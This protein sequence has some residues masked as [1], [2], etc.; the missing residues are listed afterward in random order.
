MNDHASATSVMK[1]TGK[2]AIIDLYIDLGTGNNGLIL[3]N[4]G[5]KL[6]GVHINGSDLASAKTCLHLDHASTGDHAIIENIDIEGH[7]TYATGLLIDNFTHSNFDN[8]H[9]HECLEGIKIVGATSDEN[10]F[11]NI[12][13]GDC[14]HASGIG[15]NID[16]GNE[17]H[18]NKISFHN[19]TKN[20]DDEVKDHEWTNKH[21]HFPIEIIPNDLDGFLT[22]AG[23]ATSGIEADWGDPV[24]FAAEDEI[25]FPFRV[26]GVHVEPTA[27]EWHELRFSGNAGVTYYDRILFEGNKREAFAAPS[28]TEFIFNTGTELYCQMRSESGGNNCQVWIEIQKI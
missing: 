22:T 26:V 17:Q 6:L 24:V 25:D 11:N 20:V 15:I 1:F 7:P 14:N 19:N 3:T 21:G 23:D 8:L 18:F 5:P 16:A 28:G 12:D 4:D 10:Y 27:N 9:I 13:I 2:V